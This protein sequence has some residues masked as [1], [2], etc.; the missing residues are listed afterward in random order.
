MVFIQITHKGIN[1]A[2]NLE[3]LLAK[4]AFV[5]PQLLHDREPTG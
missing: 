3:G 2:P 1:G 5:K 4:F